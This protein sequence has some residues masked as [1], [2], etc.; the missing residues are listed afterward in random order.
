M[1]KEKKLVI[2]IKLKDGTART[3]RT[4]V[5][6][7]MRTF[8]HINA[9][10][11]WVMFIVYRKD[12]NEKLKMYFNYPNNKKHPLSREEINYSKF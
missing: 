10:L 8:K 11:N 9:D 5:I 7:F 1:L 12:T 4:T 3:R 6:G 2:W